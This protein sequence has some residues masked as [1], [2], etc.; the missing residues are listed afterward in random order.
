VQVDDSGALA[1]G[2]RAHVKEKSAL[3]ENITDEPGVLALNFFS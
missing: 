1:S 3:P 2:E